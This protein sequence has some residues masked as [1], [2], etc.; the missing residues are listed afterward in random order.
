MNCFF[1]LSIEKGAYVPKFQMGQYLST[2]G[3]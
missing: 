3:I 1:A 2:L